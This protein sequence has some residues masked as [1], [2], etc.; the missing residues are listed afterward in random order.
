MSNHAHWRFQS[1]QK[2]QDSIS[3]IFVKRTLMTE[4]KIIQLGFRGSHGMD[5]FGW[6][7]THVQTV[8]DSGHLISIAVEELLSLD[9]PHAQLCDPTY[10]IFRRNDTCGF[11]IK[12]HVTVESSWRAD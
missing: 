1:I 9:S 7:N 12:K 2:T 8:C 5:F 11:Q 10:W 4:I 6:V 3:N